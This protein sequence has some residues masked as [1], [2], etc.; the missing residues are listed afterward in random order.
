MKT[1]GRLIVSGLFIASFTLQAWGSAPSQTAVKLTPSEQRFFESKIS[2]LLIKHCQSCHSSEKTPMGGLQLDSRKGWMAGG[3][4]GSAIVP[5]QPEK[6]LLI[7]AIRYQDPELAMPPQG[8]LSPQEI[9]ALEQWVLLGAPDPR[10]EPSGGTPKVT[11]VNLEEGRRFWSF[12]P[13]DT[14]PL[15]E[16]KNSTW[17]SSPLDYFVLSRLEEKGMKPVRP[18]DRRTWIR[19]ATLD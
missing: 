13:L 11:T 7:Q 2:P 10:A 8:I 4:R 5:G 17:I 19:R 14:R 15:P 9:E 16:V 12:Q 1:A 6:S 3:S 18:A